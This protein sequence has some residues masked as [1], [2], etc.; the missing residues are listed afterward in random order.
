MLFQDNFAFSHL[1]EVHANALLDPRQNVVTGAFAAVSS[2][3]NLVIKKR[4]CIGRIS[5]HA[6]TT[7]LAG[8]VD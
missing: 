8:L 7:P 4:V 1:Q 2:G 5:S 3:S 6:V